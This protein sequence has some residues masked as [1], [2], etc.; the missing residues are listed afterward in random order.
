MLSQLWLFGNATQLPGK[1]AQARFDQENG[2]TVLRIAPELRI[3][4]FGDAAGPEILVNQ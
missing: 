2:R 1:F 3:D 4:R